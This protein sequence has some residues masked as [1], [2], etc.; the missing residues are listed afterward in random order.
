MISVQ[1]S[2][3]SKIKVKKNKKKFT[4]Q[5]P[6]DCL[7]HEISRGTDLILLNLHCKP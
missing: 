7:S 3:A 6:G 5:D 4:Y 1:Q 2:L